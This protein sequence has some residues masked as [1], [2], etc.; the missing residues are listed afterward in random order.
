MSLSQ[1]SIIALLLINTG[2]AQVSHNKELSKQGKLQSESTEKDLVQTTNQSFLS[3]QE[4]IVKSRTWLIK[5]ERAY[6]ITS[7]DELN[8]KP[9]LQLNMALF[10]PCSFKKLEESKQ[11]SIYFSS[12]SIKLT[13][14]QILLKEVNL[15]VNR[16]KLTLPNLIMNIKEPTIGYFDL[17]WQRGSPWIETGVSIY[18]WSIQLTPTI[19]YSQEHIGLG[20]HLKHLNQYLR[21][22]I[23]FDHN[24]NSLRSW[25]LYGRGGNPIYAVRGLVF[26]QPYTRDDKL[27]SGLPTIATFFWQRPRTYLDSKLVLFQNHNW[28]SYLNYSEYSQLQSNYYGEQKTQSVGGKEINYS[29][30]ASKNHRFSINHH[31]Q[32]EISPAMVKNLVI[33][34]QGK[35]ELA[36]EHYYFNNRLPQRLELSPKTIFLQNF[37]L[38][39]RP[40][41]F[42]HLGQSSLL[43]SVYY[44]HGQDVFNNNS[45]SSIYGQF[46]A[47]H[48]IQLVSNSINKHKH[49]ISFV[50]RFISNSVFRESNLLPDRYNSP[51]LGL[52]L[53]Q[54]LSHFKY[55][56]SLNNWLSQ[57]INSLTNQ[58]TL[59]TQLRVSTQ[60]FTVDYMQ[61][62]KTYQRMLLGYT[63]ASIVSSLQKRT[64]FVNLI[65]H[66]YDQGLFNQSSLESFSEFIPLSERLIVFNKQINHDSVGLQSSVDLQDISQLNLGFSFS[67]IS[68][69][70]N[71]FITNSNLK[72]LLQT[73]VQLLSKQSEIAWSSACGCWH[74]KLTGS[75]RPI[76]SELDSKEWSIAISFGLGEAN[77]KVGFTQPFR[78][79]SNSL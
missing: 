41:L 47:E 9:V 6:V 78:L 17:A 64:G 1:Y 10:Y 35:N 14:D 62:P 54:N 79:E 72:D 34:I 29:Q 12:D 38:M 61:N 57:N 66:R 24:I 3:F 77:A 53:K 20:G 32:Q 76:N 25:Y 67:P 31:Y 16:Y 70:I 19:I 74:I 21:T 28:L 52:L 33:Q 26:Q 27:N 55:T 59:S 44:H 51:N 63:K 68:F 5:A 36:L 40:K 56:L 7:K 48:E 49:A 18:P 43:A 15:H 4:L 22:Q 13:K 46:G 2:F 45:S 58:V 11:A 8:Q 71:L 50:P 37:G 60:E 69:N 39:L 30:T 75:Y 42:S 65:Y 73:K 23:L